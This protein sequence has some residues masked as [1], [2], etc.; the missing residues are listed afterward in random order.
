[1]KKIGMT[2]TGEFDHPLIEPGNKF[3]RHV[4]YEIRISDLL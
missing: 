3:S 2:K 1:M 4:L